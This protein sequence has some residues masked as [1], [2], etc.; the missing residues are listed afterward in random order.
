MQYT[1]DRNKY[2]YIRN[3]E[4]LYLKLVVIVSISALIAD[5]YVVKQF[6]NILN[7]M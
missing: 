1:K 2:K 3:A 4:N 7:E 5:Y 6:I